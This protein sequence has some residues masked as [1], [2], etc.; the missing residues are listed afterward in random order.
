MTEEMEEEVLGMC[1]YS[2]GVYERGLAQGI[3]QGIAQGIAQGTE[4]ILLENI[5]SVMDGLGMP[6]EKVL[7]LLKVPQSEY[8]KYK[9]L[10]K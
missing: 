3:E 1:D 9:K 6:L 2:V 10:I 5:K 7:E 4:S 8:E